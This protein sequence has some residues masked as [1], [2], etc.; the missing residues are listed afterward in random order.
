MSVS[1]D[2]M[3]CFLVK[4]NFLTPYC[5]PRN[6]VWVFNLKRLR[7]HRVVAVVRDVSDF[8]QVIDFALKHAKTLNNVRTWTLQYTKDPSE[9]FV[10]IHI[11]YEK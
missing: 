7:M 5:G 4:T 3:A 10:S 2:D 9:L 6:V 1:L 11:Y 8:I